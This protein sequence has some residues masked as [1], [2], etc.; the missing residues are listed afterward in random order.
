MKFDKGSV[1]GGEELDLIGG[2]GFGE[3]DDASVTLGSDGGVAEL[4]KAVD[5]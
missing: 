4:L 1:D 2:N 5:E 3:R